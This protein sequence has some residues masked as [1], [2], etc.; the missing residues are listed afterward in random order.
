MKNGRTDRDWAVVAFMAFIAG[1]LLVWAMLSKHPPQPRPP[2]DVDWPAWVQAIGSL[3]GIAV[4]IAVPMSVARRERNR[5][6]RIELRRSR[7]YA[8][9][10]VTRIDELGHAIRAAQYA[11]EREHEG[12]YERA[13][14]YLVDRT[15]GDWVLQT[16][17]LGEAAGPL[18]AALYAAADIANALNEWDFWISSGGLWYDD[19][20][21]PV[22]M[23][24]PPDIL[25]LVRIADAHVKRAA[26]EVRA[27]LQD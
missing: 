27:L 18:Q 23:D 12:G 14:Q 3:I 21:G 24:V 26:E 8:L 6:E 1:A 25:P 7:T 10:L 20:D 9:L 22:E 5:V 13:H 2:S 15:R 16:H 11:G 19:I 17:E 4:A